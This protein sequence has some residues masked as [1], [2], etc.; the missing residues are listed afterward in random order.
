MVEL[1]T[2]P[3]PL[4]F[5]FFLSFLFE[6]ESLNRT[7]FLNPMGPS[8]STTGPEPYFFSETDQQDPV[9]DQRNPI[10]WAPIRLKSSRALPS[11]ISPDSTCLGQ[12]RL[13][14]CSNSFTFSRE[15]Y[16]FSL[17]VVELNR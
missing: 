8:T 16:L 3:I 7:S 5:N 9:L 11:F 13:W 12:I 4:L 15:Y 6:S 14:P 17:P 10:N 1:V 2:E